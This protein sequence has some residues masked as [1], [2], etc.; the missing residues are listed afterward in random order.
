MAKMRHWKQRF[1]PNAKMVLR[2]RMKLG[3]EWVEG[4]TVL[5]DELVAKMGRHRLRVWWEANVIELAPEEKAENEAAVASDRPIRHTG[6]GWY[7]VDL[8]DGSTERVHGK[9]A[10]EAMLLGEDDE[11]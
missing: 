10:A 2:R 3:G 11:G 9:A 1:D 8:P 5:S 7:D 4:G 6:G